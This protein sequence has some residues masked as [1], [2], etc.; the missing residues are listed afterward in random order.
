MIKKRARKRLDHC[1]HSQAVNLYKFIRLILGP[2]ITD[3]DIARRWKM[4]SKNFS[5][6]K[7]GRYPVPRLER[8]EQLARVL[9]INKH[10]VFHVAGG[11]TAESRSKRGGAS[12]VKVFNLI[13]K[14]D[15]RG[16]IKLL[17]A[18]MY[19][20]DPLASLRRERSGATG[21]I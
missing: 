19:R 6:F 13:R 20:G 9:G 18:P 2:D 5:E 16:Q 14:N 7:F 11:A 8:L 12:A 4:D 1:P 15:L 10:L 3:A 21:G 17:F